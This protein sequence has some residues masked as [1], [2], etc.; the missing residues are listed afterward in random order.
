MA[1]I[2]ASGP[3]CRELRRL[4]PARPLRVRFWDGEHLDEAKGLAGEQRTPVWTL[5]LRAA[6]H[7]FETGLT[8]VYQVLTRRPD[9][10]A[11]HASTPA[12]RG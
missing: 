3:L 9:R 6:R 7:G 1:L 12:E 2:Q 8:A 5:Y 11:L 4:F 10:T